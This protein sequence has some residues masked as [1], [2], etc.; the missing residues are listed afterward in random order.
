MWPAAASSSGPGYCLPFR[1]RGEAHGGFATRGGSA[2]DPLAQ[3]DEALRLVESTGNA[4]EN[5]GRVMDD[6]KTKSEQNFEDIALAADEAFQS[7]MG[8]I[9][10]IAGNLFGSKAGRI[11]R[12]PDTSGGASDDRPDN[13]VNARNDCVEWEGWKL[14]A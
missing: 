1:G 4:F 3:I 14:A 11:S 13:R 6:F 7:I 10:T 8:S 12:A 9:Q 5:I 2:K